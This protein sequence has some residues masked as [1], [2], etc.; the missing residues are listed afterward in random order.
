MFLGGRSVERP[1]CQ[2][3]T[4]AAADRAE[5]RRCL[6]ADERVAPA[7]EIDVTVGPCVTRVGNGTQL[8]QKPQLLERSLDLGTGRP[9]L[10]PVEREQRRLDGGPLPIRP[11]VR[12]KTRPQ[13]ARASDVQ[14]LIVA[15]TEEVDAG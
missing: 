5:R 1:A 15:V 3:R 12:A 9:P 2:P 7:A 4:C 10:D 6:C 8:P 13:V 11:E 14:H